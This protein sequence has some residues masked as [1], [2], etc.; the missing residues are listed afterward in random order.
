MTKNCQN[1]QTEM[2]L[3]V[4]F[5]TQIIVQQSRKTLQYNKE[6]SF[7][8]LITVRTTT[9]TGSLFSFG[10]FLL[11]QEVSALILLIVN[12]TSKRNV[13]KAMMNL[14]FGFNFPFGK[15]I[16]VFDFPFRKF[17][18]IFQTWAS[19]VEN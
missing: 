2:M 8:T 13:D 9:R 15:C 7:L 4:N 10:K 18:C 19:R 11:I 1:S 3:H 17:L 6:F 14:T 12:K 16:P 5:T